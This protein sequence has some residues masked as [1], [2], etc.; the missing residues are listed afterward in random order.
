MKFGHFDNTN[1]EYV[2]DRPDT[3]K[4]WSNYLGSTE[5]GAIITNNAGGYSFYKSAAQGR[6]TRLVFNNTPI[7]QPGRNIYIRDMETGDY[8]TNAWQPVGK[9]LK[10]YKSVC[11]HG[12][13]YTIITSE[14]SNIQSDTCYFVPLGKNYECWQVKLTNY[15]DQKRKLRLFTYVEYTGHWIQQNDLLNLQYS[16][17]T[18][19]MAV[20]NGIIDHGVNAYLPYHPEDFT[21]GDS[22]RHSFLGIIGAKPTGFDTD[23]DR[24]LGTYNSYN[25]P[26]V[27]EKGNCTNS[28]AVSGNGCGVQQIDIKLAPGES[29]EFTVVMGIGKAD[30]ESKKAIENLKP[31]GKIDEE[32]QKVR[33]Y[34][35]QRI[36]ALQADTP[37]PDLNNMLQVW[38]PYNSLITY[39]WSRAA[40]LIYSGTRD[41]LGYR[42][43]LQDILG[44]L[45][46]IP[47][48]AGERLKLMITGQVSTGGAM[49]VVKPFS[50]NPGK[51][52]APAEEEYRSDDCMWLFNTIPAYVRETGNIDFY[53]EVL[54]YADQGEDTVLGHL[55]RAMEFNLDRSGAHNLPCGLLADWND[56][57]QLGQKGETVFVAM[58]LRYA[59]KTYIEICELLN[60]PEEID[61]AGQHLETLDKNIDKY[62]WDGEYYLRAYRD[63]GMK[64]G[65]HESE[66]GQ[67][68]LNPQSWAVFSG[69]ASKE[70]AKKAMNSVNDR[71]ASK[72]GI[73][74]CEPYEFADPSVIKATL[75]PKGAKENGSIFC[76]TQGWAIIAETLLGKGNRAYE[77]LK[78]YLPAAYND[79]AEIREIEPYVYCQ[80]TFSQHHSR[81]G[82]SRLPWLSGTASWSYYSTITY[83]LGIQPEYDGLTID[84]CIPE[85]WPGFTARR[86]FRDKILNIEV[87]N[88]DNVQKGIK[89][90]LLNDEKLATNFIPE[91]LMKDENNLIAIMG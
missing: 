57:L 73:V 15:G 40:S 55:R 37:D 59:L 31:P 35:H 3:P 4:S 39:A 33:D 51:E 1:K 53:N 58:Q 23:K 25:N 20:K 6:F 2:I 32:F 43:T 63:D 90:L 88:P 67:L 22:S 76:H 34:W 89:E 64:F 12:T 27:V 14:Y 85:H 10:Q 68:W 42:D 9:P 52:K 48:E 65:S 82:A 72:H 83:V 11:R 86:K 26:A 87:Q 69:H 5:Y 71:L 61:W 21:I 41:G 7:D 50:H 47:G 80:S 54:P 77:Y 62:A 13:G 16:Q 66:E 70:K 75:F 45:H 84:P 78:A 44:V 91:K 29:K 60:K 36:S 79:N 8:W 17:Y 19:T 46:N 81:F 18:M 38:N 28:L 24:F 74:V 49:P 30:L 56:C